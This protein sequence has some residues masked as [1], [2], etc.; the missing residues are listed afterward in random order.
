MLN[1]LSAAANVPFRDLFRDSRQI[2]DQA[3]YKSHLG[4]VPY[5]RNEHWLSFFGG[6]ADNLIRSLRRHGLRCRM[7]LGISRRSPA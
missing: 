7:R 4:D 5:E 2:Y 6:I 3:Y 1:I